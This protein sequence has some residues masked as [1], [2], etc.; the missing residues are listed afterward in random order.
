[1]SPEEQEK[2]GAQIATVALLSAVLAVATEHYL[3]GAIIA[4]FGFLTLMAASDRL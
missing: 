2:R 4:A 3:F 1:M